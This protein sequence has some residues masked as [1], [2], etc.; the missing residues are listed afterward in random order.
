MFSLSKNVLLTRQ[1]VKM[2]SSAPASFWVRNDFYYSQEAVRAETEITRDIS[3][4]G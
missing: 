2:F 4:I 3:T 1:N